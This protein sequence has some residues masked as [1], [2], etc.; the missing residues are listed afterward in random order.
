MVGGAWRL[1]RTLPER[2]GRSR[3]PQ[4]CDAALGAAFADA[5]VK[6]RRQDCDV[7]AQHLTRWERDTTLDV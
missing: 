5:Y 4:C 3:A 7:Y 2:C 1:A 6:M